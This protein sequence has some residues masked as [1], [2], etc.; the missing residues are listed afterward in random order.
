MSAHIV[1]IPDV[2]RILLKRI[3]N[4]TVN[5]QYGE[6]NIPHL[7]IKVRHGEGGI[8]WFGLHVLWKDET[9]WS[10]ELKDAIEA[11]VVDGLSKIVDIR[12]LE[13]DMKRLAESVNDIV[14]SRKR[15]V[16]Y[17]DHNNEMINL[18]MEANVQV[19][20]YR[21]HPN[22]DTLSYGGYSGEICMN[23]RWYPCFIYHRSI[24]LYNYVTIETARD[25]VVRSLS[26]M[27][28]ELFDVE[29]NFVSMDS[30][31]QR[32]RNKRRS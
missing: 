13:T 30:E 9:N 14:T 17:G 24:I 3:E 4:Y 7:C 21:D 15:P 10:P 18:H 1:E 20:V 5:K 6:S 8:A 25:M 29:D 11:L 12:E 2:I 28:P 26:R 22:P 19:D 31:I 16:L 32:T 27:F 23:G